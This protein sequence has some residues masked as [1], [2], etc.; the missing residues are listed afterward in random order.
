VPDSV[1]RIPPPPARTP[2]LDDD[3]AGSRLR[4]NLWVDHYLPHWSTPD[5]SRARYDLDDRDLVGREV[6]GRGLGLRID[7]DQLDWRSEDAPLRVSSLQTGTFSGPLGSQR[8]THRHRPD[9]LTVRTAT[10]TRLLWAPSAGRVDITVSASVDEGCMLAAW[11]VGTEHLTERDSGEVCVFEID[12][13]GVGAGSSRARC[14]VKAH[15]DDRLR[16]DMSEVVVAVNAAQP[17]T[18]TAIWR[19]EDT[20][21]GCAGVVVKRSAQ[22]PLYPQF[23]LINLWEIGPRAQPASAYPKTARVHRVRGWDLG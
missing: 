14:G 4:D 13:A 19:P 17:H 3:F 18:W 8:G 16:T 10:P 5:R 15:H 22:A 21:I 9:G 1:D 20:V 7:D 6:A 12:A 11:L 23:L 2:D